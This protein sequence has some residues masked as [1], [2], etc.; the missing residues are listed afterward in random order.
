MSRAWQEIDTEL[1]SVNKLATFS[2][3]CTS[4]TH[5]IITLSFQSPIKGMPGGLLILKS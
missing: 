1:I 4:G 2:N 3:Q 5:Q